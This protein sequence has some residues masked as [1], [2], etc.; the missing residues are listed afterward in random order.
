MWNFEKIWNFEKNF[1]IWN[2]SKKSEIFEKKLEKKVL[3][4]KKNN[5]RKSG[6]IFIR[7]RRVLEQIICHWIKIFIQ[8]CEYPHSEE[9]NIHEKICFQEEKNHSKSRLCMICTKHKYCTDRKLIN[10]EWLQIKFF[11]NLK[12]IKIKKFSVGI[13]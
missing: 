8:W 13:Y 3:F 4:E 9:T 1:K 12:W 10:L 11:I 5:F 7:I 2:F 6:S